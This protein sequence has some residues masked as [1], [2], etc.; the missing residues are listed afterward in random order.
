VGL[1][2]DGISG[3]GFHYVLLERSLAV[4]TPITLYFLPSVMLFAALPFW[5]KTL[6]QD[7]QS[8]MVAPTSIKMSVA[9]I[10]FTSILASIFVYKAIGSSNAT[11]ASIIEITYP[12]FVAIVAF[13][14]LQQTHFNAQVLIGGALIL[15]GV[16]LVIL[17]PVGNS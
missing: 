4:V 8:I 15:T 14:L 16:V 7:V 6:V 5:Y 13:F 12:L 9:I 1:G 11:V 10:M 2:A 17:S 3:M